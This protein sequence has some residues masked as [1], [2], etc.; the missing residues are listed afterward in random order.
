MRVKLVPLLQLVFLA[1]S[2]ITFGFSHYRERVADFLPLNKTCL[3]KN[4]TVDSHYLRILARLFE[5]LEP[6]AL[7]K[8]LLAG[9]KITVEPGDY[10]F[11]Q[12]DQHTALYIV[13]S[14]RLRAVAQDGSGLHILGDI[15][16]GEPLTC[17]PA[18]ISVPGP[19]ILYKPLPPMEFPST[20]LITC[21]SRKHRT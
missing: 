19:T 15:A 14:G 13:L 18:T 5:G 20:S 8:I 6:D 11:R 1:L 2:L 10:L 21:R 7:H 17:R 12:G 9:Q 4:A 16:E 3:E